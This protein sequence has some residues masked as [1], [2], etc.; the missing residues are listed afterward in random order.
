VLDYITIDDLA[1]YMEVDVLTTENALGAIYAAEAAVRQYLGQDITSSEGVEYHDGTGRQVMRLRQR[2]VRRVNY[3]TV[4]EVALD[5][6]DWKLR[7]SRVALPNGY[8]TWGYDNVAVSY[9]HGYDLTSQGNYAIPADIRLVT[10]SAARRAYQARGDSAVAAG[11]IQQE[12]I[13]SYSYQLFNDAS[14]V[15][16]TVNLLAS[17]MSVLDMYKISMVV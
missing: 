16:A 1:D 3:I 7:G 5:S 9:L 12:T 17:E 15:G 8:F 13:G 11:A 2:P 4:D 10:L 14:T 6:G